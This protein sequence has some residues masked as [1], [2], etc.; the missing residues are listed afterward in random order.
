MSA[1]PSGEGGAAVGVSE[2]VEARARVIGVEGYLCTAL[3]LAIETEDQSRTHRDCKTARQSVAE[4]LGVQRHTLG[5]WLGTERGTM[6]SL[7]EYACL[8]S[9]E[10]TL[11]LEARRCLWHGLCTIAGH[12]LRRDAGRWAGLV[13][14]PAA[15]GPDASKAV[16]AVPSGGV[17]AET[18]SLGAAVGDVQRAVAEAGAVIDPAE[19][20][21]LLGKVRTLMGEAV[22][23][24]DALIRGA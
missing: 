5:R 23:M 14:P 8:L 7:A 18:L 10:A 11:G 13:D 16:D 22:Q 24:L 20:A 15:M 21:A 6:I 17:V 1:R 2:V 19:R 12:E 4:F 9:D 3:R